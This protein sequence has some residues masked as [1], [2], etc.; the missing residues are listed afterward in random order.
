MTYRT[1]YSLIVEQVRLMTASLEST[2]DQRNRQ[3]TTFAVPGKFNGTGPAQ[4]CHALVIKR[5]TPGISMK[6]FR[7][8]PVGIF[9]A[10]GT[11]P[12]GNKTLQVKR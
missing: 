10:M 3:M 12:G 8:L 11:S 4:D 6:R 9:M 2:R 7:P 1:S 5:L